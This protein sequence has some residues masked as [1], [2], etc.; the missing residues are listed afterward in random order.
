[1]T[2]NEKHQHRCEVKT[3]I[4]NINFDQLILS[5]VNKPPY[6]LLKFVRRLTKFY[7]EIHICVRVFEQ[8][9]T[10]GNVL[11]VGK[12]STWLRWLRRGNSSAL[13]ALQL[14]RCMHEVYVKLLCDLWLCVCVPINSRKI[15][16]RLIFRSFC[17]V[18]I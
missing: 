14:T 16:S 5:P 11:L 10:T 8:N 12:N 2:I 9:W 1:M 13:T 3:W 18:N 6:H 15:P 4:T 17:C 7:S